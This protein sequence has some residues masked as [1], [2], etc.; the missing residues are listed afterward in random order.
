MY[1]WVVFGLYYHKWT[2]RYFGSMH[3]HALKKNDIPCGMI[4]LRHTWRLFRANSD[5]IFSFVFHVDILDVRKCLSVVL[6]GITHLSVFK[7]VKGLVENGLS[8]ILKLRTSN[9]IQYKVHKRYNWIEI[10]FLIVISF[11]RIF[12]V[13]NSTGCSSK[14]IIRTHYSDQ[15]LSLWLYSSKA[16]FLFLAL[17]CTYYTFR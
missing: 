6:T 16:Y 12:N 13:G 1:C 11:T 3:V 8:P 17:S 2:S 14:C 10:Y 7:E 5:Y 15:H 4:Y 9:C